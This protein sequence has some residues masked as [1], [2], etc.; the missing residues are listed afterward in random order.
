[1]FYTRINKMKVFNNREGF[2]GLFNRGAGLHTHKDNLVAL[3]LY[4]SPSITLLRIT[5]ESWIACSDP[6]MSASLTK[7]GTSDE[8]V[9]GDESATE[10]G[11]IHVPW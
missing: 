3:P 11:E 7:W 9:G 2:L 8:V 10:G 5:V 4:V 1:M 6:Q